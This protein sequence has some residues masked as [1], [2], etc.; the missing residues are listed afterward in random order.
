M[1]W[2][3]QGGHLYCWAMLILYWRWQAAAGGMDASVIREWVGAAWE[4]GVGVGVGHLR[5]CRGQRLWGVGVEGVAV[6]EVVKL[7]PSL[8]EGVAGLGVEEQL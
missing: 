7:L 2:L 4:E 5:I 6:V 8:Q 3:Y 1:S